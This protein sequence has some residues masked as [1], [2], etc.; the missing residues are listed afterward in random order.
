MVVGVPVLNSIGNNIVPGSPAIVHR[1]VGESVLLTPKPLAP[2]EHAFV[3]DIEFVCGPRLSDREAHP[4]VEGIDPG[5]YE[6]SY[7]PVEVCNWNSLLVHRRIP[8]Q[9][10]HLSWYVVWIRFK[11]YLLHCGVT[12]ICFGVPTPT[13]LFISCYSFLNLIAQK[14]S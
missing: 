14:Q 7:L 2:A 3:E 9:R 13:Q 8:L 11:L 1:V 5:L 4:G 6:I 12:L 10:S